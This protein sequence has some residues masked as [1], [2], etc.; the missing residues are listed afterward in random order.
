MEKEREANQAQLQ[1]LQIKI[2]ESLQQDNDRQRQV[3]E[4][5]QSLKSQEEIYSS[6]LEISSK[7]IDS[8]KSQIE[9]I[10]K[11]EQAWAKQ[12]ADLESAHEDEL[13]KLRSQVLSAQSSLEGIINRCF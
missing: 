11:L 1:A 10:M 12:K 13:A 6:K 4:Y 3:E 5:E 9:K 2:A 7:E 8:L